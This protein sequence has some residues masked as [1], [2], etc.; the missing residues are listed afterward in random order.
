MSYRSTLSG[1]RRR[2]LLKLY[3]RLEKLLRR[4]SGVRRKPWQTVGDYAGA[5]TVAN[6]GVRK[7]LDW[8]TQAVWQAAYNPGELSAG[9]VQQGRK[10]LAR[11]NAALKSGA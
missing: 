3:S 7:Q 11:I 4:K 9:L 8:F 5:A 2:E 6:P 10:H 1:E